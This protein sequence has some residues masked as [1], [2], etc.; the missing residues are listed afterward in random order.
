MIPILINLGFA[1]GTAA[2]STDPTQPSVD[3]IVRRHNVGS[4][5]HRRAADVS[6]SVRRREQDGSETIQRWYS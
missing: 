6:G 4:S 2:V 1:G 3:T 5:V